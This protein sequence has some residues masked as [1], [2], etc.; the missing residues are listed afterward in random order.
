[1]SFEIHPLQ[2]N[3]DTIIRCESII[4]DRR[5]VKSSS[6]DTEKRYVIRAPMILGDQEWEVE[7]TLTNRDSMGYR[8]LLGRE[9][10]EHRLLVDPAASFNLGDRSNDQIDRLYG[11]PTEHGTGLRLGYYI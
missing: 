9:A 4:V 7:L 1:M 5:N 6:G 8:M 11:K 10:M 2:Q 3:R